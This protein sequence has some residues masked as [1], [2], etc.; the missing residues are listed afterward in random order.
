MPR[1]AHPLRLCTSVA[2]F[3]PRGSCLPNMAGEA[4][5]MP[6]FTYHNVLNYGEPSEDPFEIHP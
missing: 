3:V 2:S 6:A 5:Y 4:L 1:L